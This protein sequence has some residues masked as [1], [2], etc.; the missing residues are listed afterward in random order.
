MSLDKTSLENAIKSLLE[1]QANKKSPN[2]KS[3]DSIAEFARDLANAI[4]VFIKSGT[5]NIAA[6]IAVQVVPGTGTGS[7]VANGTGNIL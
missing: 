2:D 1:R 5:V 7:T 4:D 6:G 3:E